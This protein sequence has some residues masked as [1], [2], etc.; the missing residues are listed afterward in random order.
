MGKFF[1]MDNPF[2]VAM[3]R[4]ADIFLLNVVFFICCI[5]IVTIGPAITAMFYVTLKMAKNEESYI[6]R[7]FFHSFKQNLKQG[8]IIHVI[9]LLLGLVLFGDFYITGHMVAKYNTVMRVLLLV[10]SIFYGL[11]YLYV[12]PVL[13]KFDNSVK[14][15]MRNA[16]LMAIRHLPQTVLMSIVAL[17]PLI[18]LLIKDAA[19]QSLILFV[20][21]LLGPGAIAYANSIVF[22]KVF[23]KYIPEEEPVPDVPFE[24]YPEIGRYE[25][26]S[27]V[28]PTSEA[29]VFAQLRDAN[30]SSAEE[31]PSE[32]EQN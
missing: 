22:V 20:L 32:E 10:V 23:A 21:I 4:V 28:N 26:V 1:N 12:Y 24:N 5:P 30:S 29:D 25:A 13:A 9:L 3:G 8:I 19:F 18:V 2:F 27:T 31:I 11:E 16:I 14:N 6:F 7:S 15:T 17:S